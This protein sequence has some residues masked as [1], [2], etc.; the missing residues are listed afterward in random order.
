MKAPG[1]T[2]EPPGRF[3]EVPTWILFCFAILLLKILLLALDPLPKLYMGDSG[4]Y[5]WTALTGWIPEDRS[6]F[7]GFVIRWSSLWT[8]SLTSLLV[9]QV[10]LSAITCILLASIALF[11]FKLPARWSYLFGFLCAIDPLQLLYERY[12][13][14]EA[15]S[16]CFYALVLYHSFLYL[17]NRRLRDLALVQVYSVVL[18]GFR[19]SFLLLVQCDTIILPVLAFLPLIPLRFRRR[20][21]EHSPSWPAFRA[22]GGHLVLSVAIM[23]S[24]H[25]GYKR[26]NGL[27]SHRE[28]DYLYS[29]GLMLLASCAPI[30]E[31]DDAADARLGDLIKR[32]DELDLK[33]F[34]LRN[35]QRFSPDRL[36]DQLAKIE[37]DPSKADRLAKDTA[38]RA[39]RRNPLG[40]LLLG[41]HTYTDFWHIEILKRSAE[42]DFGFANPPGDDVLTELATYFH[43][44]Q[45]K[46]A[47]EKSLL[48]WY[49]VEAWPY[50]ILILL[51]PFLSVAVVI[52]CSQR[53]PAIL[54]FIHISLLLTVSMIFGGDSVR[55]FQSISFVTLLVIALGTQALMTR[56]RG[57]NEIGMERQPVD[58]QFS[59]T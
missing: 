2:A 11:I 40:I 3:R 54:L 7:Y 59:Q 32:G 48:Q 31:P 56:R 49:Y 26:A 30:L 13:M 44:A 38:L 34:Y 55:F 47:T 46:D 1:S 9:L 58:N 57:R 43:L 39:L 37:P 8:E 35:S 23:F 53:P 21:T 16:L 24:L 14:T 25:T 15:I 36:I 18:I 19:M 27:L 10:L 22:C 33:N 28:P 6:Y 20:P 5:L 45:Q 42:R 17:R 12:V 29:A 4:S 41:L 51:A 52:I 50:Y